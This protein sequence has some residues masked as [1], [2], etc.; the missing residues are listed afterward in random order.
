MSVQL[1]W[2]WARSRERLPH[3]VTRRFSD[4]I[5]LLAPLALGAV[6]VGVLVA[7][8]VVSHHDI[9]AGRVVL[10]PPCP[11][12]AR[13]EADCPSCGLTRAFAAL[14][15]GEWRVAIRYHALAPAIYLLWWFAALVVAHRN[16]R[17][18]RAFRAGAFRAGAS[19]AG[20][21]GTGAHHPGVFG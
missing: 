19:R 5:Q 15:H 17:A 6:L 9:E 4:W 13:F 20:A 16:W 1:S 18:V 11:T 12:R 2:F 8:F 14:S 10:S 21:F 7:S 3:S